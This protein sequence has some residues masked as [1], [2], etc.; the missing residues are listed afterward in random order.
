MNRIIKWKF[1]RYVA[2]NGFTY[3]LMLSMTYALTEFAG[4]YYFYSY[5]SSMVAAIVLSFFLGMRWIFNVEGKVGQRFIR[6]IV[7]LFV[8]NAVNAVLVRYLTEFVGVH[9]MLSILIVTGSIFIFK[10]IAYKRNV[11]QENI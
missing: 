6:Y 7:L 3:S 4:V 11:F 10:Y 9:Y 2:V 8:F 5:L 1:A